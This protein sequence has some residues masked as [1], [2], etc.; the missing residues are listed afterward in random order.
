MRISLAAV[1][2]LQAMLLLQYVLCSM[3]LASSVSQ[4]LMHISEV[5]MS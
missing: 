5:M 3:M 2:C 4:P 1:C